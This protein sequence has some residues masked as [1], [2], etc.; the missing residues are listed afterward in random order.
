MCRVSD[1]VRSMHGRDG[2]IVLDIRQGQ[3]FN[4]NLVGSRILELLKGEASEAEIVDS[5]IHEF[6]VTRQIAE[7]DVQKFCEALRKYHLIERAD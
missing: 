6:G 4:V 3:M 1:T 2:A 5:I 7:N